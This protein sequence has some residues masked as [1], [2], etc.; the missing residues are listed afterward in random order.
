M[1][2]ATSNINSLKVRLARVEGWPTDIQPD[3]LW[4]QETKLANS[5][6]PT[7]AFE[8]LRYQSVSHGGNGQST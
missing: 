1:R 4:L 8:T 2:V 7:T 3:V 5:D 6:F